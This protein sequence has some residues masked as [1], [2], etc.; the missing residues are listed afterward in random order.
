MMTIQ[1]HIDEDQVSLSLIHIELSK[2][3]IDERWIA[4]RDR[5]M[6]G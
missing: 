5:W 2:M 3:K 1:S 4:D 6:E